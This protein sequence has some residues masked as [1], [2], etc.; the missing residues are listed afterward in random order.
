LK[1]AVDAAGIELLA[2]NKLDVLDGLETIKVCVG[3]EL[4]GERLAGVP[5]P[6]DR[7]AE[8][9]PIYEELPGWKDGAAGAA[10]FDALPRSAQDYVKL[11]EAY[12]GAAVAFV[13][14]GPEREDGFRR[15]DVFR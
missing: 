7:L 15:R 6:F 11:I 9:K 14:T 12:V 3:Y 8:V 13:S 1:Y 10:S 5:A 4:D 2:L